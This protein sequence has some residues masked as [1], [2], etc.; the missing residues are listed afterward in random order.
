MSQANA[1]NKECIMTIL[2][3]LTIGTAV[4]VIAGMMVWSYKIY[5]ISGFRKFLPY[6][7]LLLFGIIGALFV[8]FIMS[9]K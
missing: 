3:K 8:L 5:K 6:G 7:V 4:I 1:Y 9:R 2:Y